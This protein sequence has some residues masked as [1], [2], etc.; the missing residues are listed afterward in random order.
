MKYFFLKP[1][2]IY[3]KYV[4]Y[5]LFNTTSSLHF[6]FF[7]LYPDHPITGISLQICVLFQ[8]TCILLQEMSNFPMPS[9]YQFLTIL[10]AQ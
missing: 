3:T 5:K 4:L 6:F 1:T 9:L 8:D 2:K 7:L 10:H